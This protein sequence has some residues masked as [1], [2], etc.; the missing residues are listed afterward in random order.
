MELHLVHFKSE[1]GGIDRTKRDGLAVLGI[2]FQIQEE[3]NNDLDNFINRLEKVQHKDDKENLQPFPLEKLLPRNTDMFYRYD[4]SLTTPN[5]DEIV[6]WTVFKVCTMSHSGPEI[7]K[8]SRK[9]N[10]EIKSIKKIFLR[11]IAFLAVQKLI[12]GHF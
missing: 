6:I 2:F 8:K 12:F 3:D 10:R 9:R 5:C 1:Y 11:E 7:F 4:G